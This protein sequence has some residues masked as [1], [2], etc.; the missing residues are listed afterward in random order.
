MRET[1]AS[2]VSEVWSA[3]RFRRA[4]I[5][6]AWAVCL[7]GW[8][9]VLL[10]PGRYDTIARVYVDTTSIL[11]PLLEGLAVTPRASN[12]VEVVRRVLLGR[13]GLEKVIDETPLRLQAQTPI[14]RAALLDDL[15]TSIRVTGDPQSHLYT[16]VYGDRDPR[17]SYAVVQNLLEAFLGQTVGEQRSDAENAEKFLVAQ[18]AEL[19]KRLRESEQKLAEFKK[20]NV[21]FMPDD[22]GGYFE[23][24]QREMQEVDRL[25]AERAVALNKRNELRS[26]LL[27]G[28]GSSSGG[29]VETSVDARIIEVRNKLEELLLQYTEAHPDVIAL[30]ESIAGLE[31]QRAREIEALRANRG[32][33]G[34]ARSSSTS[35]VLQNLQIALNEAELQIT[36]ADSQLSDHRA[37]SAE[38]KR[39]MNVLPEVEAE[40]ARLSRDYGINQTQY[41]QL[42]QRLESARLTGQADR[43]QDLKVKV[44]DP[45]VLPVV[46]A[47]PKRGLLLIGVLMAGLGA[48]G[49]LAW[50]LAQLHPVISNLRELRKFVRLPIIGSVSQLDAGRK[51]NIRSWAAVGGYAAALT[52]LFVVFGMLYT[53]QN[54]AAELGQA[55]LGG[56]VR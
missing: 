39:M 26:K 50:L 25:E 52:G 20:R 27:G 2:L 45:P 56:G 43:S 1:V 13:P 10:L 14:E 8:I 35:L 9:F 19:E 54:Q 12:E 41:Q 3:W 4:A 44:I 47:A 11:R 48:A 32:S 6:C 51:A 21:G 30:K 18:V 16:I 17:I 33:L 31:R 42:L 15:S 53:V 36:A 7:V 23:R 46:P 22:R 55:L 37:R 34:S 49:G 40:L 5:V 38:L 28:E 29:A 24:L